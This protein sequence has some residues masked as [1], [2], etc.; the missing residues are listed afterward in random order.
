MRITI[1][2]E[3]VTI[4]LRPGYEQTVDVDSGADY[5]VQ[6]KLLSVV[7]GRTNLAIKQV[8]RTQTAEIIYSETSQSALQENT[9]EVEIGSA[10]DEGLT[11]VTGAFVGTRELLSNNWLVMIVLVL[12][13][14]LISLFSFRNLRR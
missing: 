14:G 1:S 7:N 2:S 5:L 10:G 3:P 13:I 12:F 9:I 4:M 8:P 6:V 11:G